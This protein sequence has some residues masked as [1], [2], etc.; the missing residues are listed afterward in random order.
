MN[1]F[2]GLLSS[3]PSSMKLVAAFLVGAMLAFD[4]GGPVNKAAWFFSFSLLAPAYTTGTALW[5]S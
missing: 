3:I 1:A 2:V 4:M 5:A